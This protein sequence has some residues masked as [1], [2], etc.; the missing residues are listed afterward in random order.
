MRHMRHCIV[1]GWQSLM[2]KPESVWNC[3]TDNTTT[4]IRPRQDIRR[5]Q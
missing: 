3:K 4:K 1:A 5:R 2:T